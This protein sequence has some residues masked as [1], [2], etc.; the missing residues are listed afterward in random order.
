MAIDH[1]TQGWVNKDTNIVHSSTC[2]QR[3]SGISKP[4]D[5]FSKPLK[6]LKKKVQLL[7]KKIIITTIK[8]LSVLFKNHENYDRKRSE[9]E[10]K[11]I[12]NSTNIHP[13]FEI[14]I[15]DSFIVWV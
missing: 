10:V 9:L 12:T 6:M 15:L 1:F 13:C 5:G 7:L 14:W 2:N 4:I 3:P 11:L 8:T